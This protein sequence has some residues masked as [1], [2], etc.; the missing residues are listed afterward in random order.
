MEKLLVKEHVEDFGATFDFESL[1]ETLPR[2]KAAYP[3][4]TIFMECNEDIGLFFYYLREET[5]A[6][7]ETRIN[8][9]TT[10]LTLEMQRRRYKSLKK[11]FEKE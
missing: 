9:P 6:E 1:L 8:K 11:M 3:N 7:Y 10:K 5:D 2:I 4:E